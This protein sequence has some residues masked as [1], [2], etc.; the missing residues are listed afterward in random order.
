MSSSIWTR[1]AG[2][3][4]IRRISGTARRAVEAQHVVAT[5]KLTDSLEEQAIL[6]R[7]VERVK[8]PLPAEA[9]FEGRHFLLTTSFRY[10]P[11]RHGSRFAVRTEPSIWYGAHELGTVFAEVAYYRLWFLEGTE[12]EIASLEVELSVFSVPYRTRKGL[13]LTRAPFDADRAA[14]S[15]PSSYRESQALGG[16]MRE[17]GVEAFRYRSARDPGGGKCVGLFTP[18]AFGALAP[19]EPRTWWCRASREGVAFLR[20]DAFSRESFSFP[21]EAFLVDGG[22]PEP[23]P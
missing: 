3:S 13:D 8:P 16:A 18:R 19:S 11:L 14:I 6:E 22:L 12:A 17:A 23:A 2:S 20:K 5:A 15:S 10:P 9:G 4:E 1:R 21:R 7:I